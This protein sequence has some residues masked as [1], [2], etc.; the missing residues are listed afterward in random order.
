MGTRS[1][2]VFE[3]VRSDGRILIYATI[4]QMF[5]GGLKYIGLELALFLVNMSICSLGSDAPPKVA[6]GTGCLAAQYIAEK[7]EGPGGLCLSPPPPDESPSGEINLRH[8][9][10]V[11]VT[12]VIRNDRGKIMV[13]YNE[14]YEMTV[15]EFLAL[16]QKE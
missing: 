6:S 10:H 4:F 16:C 11:R 12:E 8:R 7:K 1:K 13:I 15:D 3:G 2:I 5:D 9:Y 14:S